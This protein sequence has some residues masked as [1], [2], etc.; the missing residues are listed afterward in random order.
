MTW[1]STL[2]LVVLVALAGSAFALLSHEP[3]G[4]EGPMRWRERCAARCVTEAR[5]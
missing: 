2:V 4:V 5:R 3:P 1:R